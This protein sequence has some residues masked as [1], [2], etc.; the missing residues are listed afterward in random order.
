MHILHNYCTPWALPVY[1]PSRMTRI[2]HHHR[3]LTR[4][5]R[6]IIHH[7]CYL[8]LATSGNNRPWAAPLFY[9]TDAQYRF[10][11]IS[12]PGSRHIR[13]SQ[14]KTQVAFAIFDSHAPEGKGNGV[15]AWG[16]MELCR[17]TRLVEALTYYHTTF[18]PCSTK[19]FTTGPYRLYRITPKRVYVLDPHAKVDQRVEI[20]L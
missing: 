20:H 9:C 13:Q 4:L 18:I 7:N 16:Q 19:A 17:G 15:Q 3:T 5:A 14:G 11:V 6:Q 8:T 1:S 2:V 10:Y 12:R